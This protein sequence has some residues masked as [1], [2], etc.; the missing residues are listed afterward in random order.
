LP[1]DVIQTLFA[2]RDPFLM[3]RKFTRF[4]RLDQDSEA[5]RSFVALEDWLN[6]G[7]ALPAAVARDCLSGWYGRNDT[8]RGRWMIAGQ[9]VDP[10][11]I[12]LPTLVLIPEKDRIVPP[13]SARVLAESI[14]DAR[15]HNPQLGHIG[16][17]VSAGAEKIVWEPL[18]EWLRSCG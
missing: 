12:R 14:P 11:R 8:A 2:T 4:A 18:A 16:M 9:F 1:V 3:A 17:I 7:V 15:I 13:C 6:D 10:G 5:A